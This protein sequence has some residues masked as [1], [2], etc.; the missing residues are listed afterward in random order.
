MS[1]DVNDSDV[2]A[3]CARSYLREEAIPISAASP[4]TVQR[5]AASWWIAVIAAPTCL[6]GERKKPADARKPGR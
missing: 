5:R 3:R 6:I 1:V 4:A 2:A